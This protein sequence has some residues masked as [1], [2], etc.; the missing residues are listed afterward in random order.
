MGGK[1]GYKSQTPKVSIIFKGLSVLTLSLKHFC[2]LP[3]EISGGGGSELSPS[4]VLL[5]VGALLQEHSLGKSDGFVPQTAAEC[6]AETWSHTTKVWGHVSM[7]VVTPI[8]GCIAKMKVQDLAEAQGGG[9][10]TSR[11]AFSLFCIPFP[12][13]NEGKEGT[14]WRCCQPSL[15]PCNGAHWVLGGQF[16][17]QEKLGYITLLCH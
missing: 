13:E 8:D 12:R 2:C 15:T 10:D 16:G 9:S 11:N 5:W 17:L 6:S 4:R 1:Q 3:F 14:K 7:Q